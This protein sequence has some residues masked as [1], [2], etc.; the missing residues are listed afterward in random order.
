MPSLRWLAP[1]GAVLAALSVMPSVANAAGMGG[2]GSMGGGMMSNGMSGMMMGSYGTMTGTAMVDPTHA[3]AAADP[4]LRNVS[5]TGLRN[6]LHVSKAW[7]DVPVSDSSVAGALAPVPQMPAA[8][9]T[10]K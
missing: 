10:S 2:A 1:L 4:S 8:G 9:G 5:H 7:Q 6:P 3:D